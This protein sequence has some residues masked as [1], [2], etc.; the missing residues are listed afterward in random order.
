MAIDAAITA[1]A[2]E[3]ARIVISRDHPR[4]DAQADERCLTPVLLS[5]SRATVVPDTV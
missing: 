1:A 4:G 3:R 5:T 2:D